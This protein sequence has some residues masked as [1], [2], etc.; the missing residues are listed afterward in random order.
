MGQTK[1]PWH[2]TIK[3]HGLEHPIYTEEALPIAMVRSRDDHA[4]SIANA[5]LMAASPDLLEVSKGVIA[6]DKDQTRRNR[7][8][9]LCCQAF[10]P[11]HYEFCPIPKA[12]AAIAR[13]EGTK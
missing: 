9:C 8:H 5:R 1:G 6:V 3:Q 2:E 7:Q 4:E 10:L 13:A 11:A 12:R